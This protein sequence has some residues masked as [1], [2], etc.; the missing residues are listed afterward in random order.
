MFCATSLA[1]AAAS[2]TFAAPHKVPA[3]DLFTGRI[4]SATHAFKLDRG[5][6]MIEVHTSQPSKTRRPLTLT[7]HGRRCRNI[8]HCVRVTGTLTGTLAA[9]ATQI[10]DAGSAYTI[11]ATGRIKPFGRVSATGTINGTGFIRVGQ[12]TLQLSLRARHGSVRIGALS[13][14]VPGFTSP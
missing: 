13:G 2:V 1:T 4:T 11:N 12:E 14:S 8:P 6:L 3:Q 7:L 10:A 5:T 9:N